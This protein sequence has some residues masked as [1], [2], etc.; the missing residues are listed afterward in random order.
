MEHR[1][2]NEHTKAINVIDIKSLNLS[3]Y[4]NEIEQLISLQTGEDKL[5]FMTTYLEENIEIIDIFSNLYY[6][7]NIFSLND[8]AKYYL[9][10]IL[11]ILDRN[12][13][14]ELFPNNNIK[15]YNL[16][17]DE[18]NPL[19]MSK[20]LFQIF[21]S[22][23][24]NIKDKEVQFTLIE[25]LFNYSEKT[26]DFCEY[27]LEDDKYIQKI[28]ELTYINNNDVILD[29][30]SIIDNIIFNQNCSP[31]D[32]EK[33]LQKIP[34]IERCKE[35]LNINNIFNIDVKISI[36]ELLNNII[37]KIDYEFY[38]NYFIDFID[39]FYS[40]LSLNKKNEEIIIIILK[41]TL[42]L[43]YDNNICK[44][45]VGSGLSY[46]F[47]ELLKLK[48]LQREYLIYLLT[49]FG[50]LFELDDIILYFFRNYSEIINIFINIIN[51]YIHTINE[52]DI[53]IL[54]ELIFCLSNIAAGPFEIQSVLA[55]SDIP[56]YIIQ[57]MKQKPNNKLYFEGI[58]FFNNI[59][60]NS[61][62]ETFTIISEFH[63]I[64]LFLKGLEYT[65]IA[66]NY[67]LCLKSIKNL[68]IR[69]REVYNTIENL[70]KEYYICQSKRKIDELTEYKNK[71]ISILAEEIREIF[72]DKMNTE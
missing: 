41:V 49:I 10:N 34:I 72:E 47:F 4:K 15:K 31:E 50:N 63:P 58:H 3:N 61:N 66:D 5:L 14:K 53:N 6:S 69:N 30:I 43:S 16:I 25:L 57:I 12:I 19:I 27:C 29:S 59:L 52:K 33:I 35:L 18:D 36:L 26:E 70:K 62:K 44:K 56:R 51:S 32:L 48:D 45:I 9:I 7:D 55:K 38:E 21:F 11:A 39:I 67:V 20:K 37:N 28:M 1:R 23:L 65:G 71:E 42:K 8:L 40:I 24:F 60:T 64:K 68:I 17:I 22:I 2:I 54:K 46:I 13:M